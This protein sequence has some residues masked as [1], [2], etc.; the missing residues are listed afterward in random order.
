MREKRDIL[1]K[2]KKRLQQ[3]TEQ[4]ASQSDLATLKRQITNI[5]YFY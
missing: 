4:H 1:R 5:K 2:L 3:A